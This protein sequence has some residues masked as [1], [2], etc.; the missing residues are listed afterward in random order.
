[1]LVSRSWSPDGAGQWVSW[2]VLLILGAEPPG[3]APPPPAPPS[4]P[5]SPLSHLPFQE[6]LTCFPS[7]Q[8]QEPIRVNECCCCCFTSV[9]FHL[10]LIWTPPTPTSLYWLHL[11]ANNTAVAGQN[12]SDDATAAPPDTCIPAS[13]L[14][15]HLLLLLLFHQQCW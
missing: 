3:G 6:F 5:P 14:L 10:H 7:K 8:L 9:M 4:P 12:V 1:M 11:S 2:C 13:P 15:F